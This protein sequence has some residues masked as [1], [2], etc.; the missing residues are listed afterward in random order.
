MYV[1]IAALTVV[2][3]LIATPG[4]AR[5]DRFGAIAYS[6]RTERYGYASDARSRGDAEARALRE[7]RAGDCVIKVWFRNSCGA[8]ATG[9][10]G[11]ITGW[12]YNN[13]LDEAKERA[14]RE[15]RAHGGHRCGIRAWACTP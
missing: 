13:S 2:A 10:E 11:R 4:P 1:R 15:C 9:D 3:L 8:L 6:V 5:G 7:C 14:L 12:A